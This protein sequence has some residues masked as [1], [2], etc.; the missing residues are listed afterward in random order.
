MLPR[1]KLN[2]AA[3]RLAGLP[4]VSLAAVGL[5]L[6]ASLSSTAS[7]ELEFQ[8]LALLQG[9]GWRL[10][11]GHFVHFGLLHLLSDSLA[12][13]LLAG[14]VERHWGHRDS[15]L[16]LLGGAPL[17][18]A[19][20]LLLAPTLHVYRGLSGLVWLC[21]APALASLWPHTRLRPALL[22]LVALAVLKL[23]LDQTTPSPLTP[24]I[25]PEL[26]AHRSGALLGVLA[27]VLRSLSRPSTTAIRQSAPP[28][29]EPRR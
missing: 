28:A 27:V 17:L 29:P 24:G 20:L 13:L 11:T 12:L 21:A 3:Q 26:W 9:E 15:G 6:I 16:L 19:L 2:T 5:A 10:W 23:S 14:L 1:A 22:L 7:G 8:R 4:L 25:P 18:A